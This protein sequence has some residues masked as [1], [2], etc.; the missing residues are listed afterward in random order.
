MRLTRVLGI[1]AGIAVVAVAAGSGV[2]ALEEGDTTEVIAY[3]DRATGV[4]AGSD[5]R[6]LG[7]KVGTVE[8]VTPRG[9]QVKVVLR[10][11]EGVRVPEG[12]HAVLVAPSLVA[13]RYIQLAPAYTSGAV[14]AD[15]AVLPAEGNAAPVE[16]DQLYESITELSEALGPEGA[17]ANGALSRLLDTGA[18][19]LDGN[20]KAIGDSIEEF[21]KATKTLDKSS[22]DLF[23]TLSYLQSF[24]TML[25]DNDGEVRA[26][27]TQLNTVAGFLADDKENLSAAL[28]ELGTA[29]GQVKTF[30]EDNRDSLKENVDALVPLTQ[31]LVDQRASIAE[32]L[33]TL[34]LTAGNLVNAYDPTN[35]TLD[36][37]TNLNE[38]SMGG[39]LTAA[40]AASTPS[41][42]SGLAAVDDARQESL[43]ALPLPPVGTV[44]GTPDKTA[45]KATEPK[46]G[47]E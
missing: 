13:D 46:E 18:A 14:L 27:E 5:L 29:L 19:N 31:I 28:T 16:V 23:E 8:S 42:F 10:V 39:P 1:G 43:P 47:D 17:N 45:G 9:E 38:L 4:Y 32:S 12:A 35:R 11:D 40:P 2:S 3:F 33:D 26:A 20:G 25:K 36:G 21:G 41:G 7:V 44:Y 22:G 30:I 15:G 6:V 34:P 37:R 24:T